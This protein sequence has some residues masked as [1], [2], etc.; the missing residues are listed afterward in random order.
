MHR[1][2]DSAT[3]MLSFHKEMY[4]LALDT[5]G[6]FCSSTN[7]SHIHKWKPGV[8]AH[9]Q[10]E[11]YVTGHAHRWA[12]GRGCLSSPPYSWKTVQGG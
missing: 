8:R 2:S 7:T 1:E 12:V 4:L 6:V 3:V 9:T 11:G 10:S 5:R